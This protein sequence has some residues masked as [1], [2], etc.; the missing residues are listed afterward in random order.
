MTTKRIIGTVL[1][2]DRLAVQSIGF[3]RFLPIG[4]PAISVEYLNNWGVDEIIVLDMFAGRQGRL[5]D[6]ALL[7]NLSVKCFV[8]L[9]IGGGI[10]TV[11]DIHQM[12]RLGADKIV[13]NTAAY[14][15]PSLIAMA[16]ADFGDQCIV[17]SIDVQALPSGKYEVYIDGGKTSTGR[18]AVDWA[19]EAESCGAGEI[20]VNSI[21]RDGSKTGYEIKLMGDISEALKIP[22][23]A[24]GGVGH[25]NHFVEVFN[26]TKIAAAAAGN[27]F[28]FTEHSVTVTKAYLKNAGLNIRMDTYA[29]YAETDYLEDGRLAKRCEDFLDKLRF[30]YYPKEII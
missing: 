6:S 22:V 17:V 27:F 14:K 2:K 18:D 7:K 1:L 9:A 11:E 13:I 5:L 4:N 28:N 15:D 26:N 29:N 3:K 25:S 24:C 23:I 12:V 21:N 8:P 10:K 16:A 19:R 20:F 30:K